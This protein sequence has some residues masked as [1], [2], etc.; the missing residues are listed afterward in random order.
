MMAA[1]PDPRPVLVEEA[2]RARG[3]AAVTGAASPGHY[4]R[5]LDKV[6]V[7]AAA[8]RDVAATP[9]RPTSSAAQAPMGV[10]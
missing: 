3:V 7:L 5:L 1:T 6:M 8:V 2:V 9:R 10:C 4:P